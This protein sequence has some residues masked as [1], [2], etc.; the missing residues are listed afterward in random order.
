MDNRSI[1]AIVLIIL[2]W[3]GYS[4]FF[5][6]THIV[7]TV[8]PEITESANN[9]IKNQD[10]ININSF[11]GQIDKQD[12]SENKITE[13][14]VKS[15]LYTIIIS[16]EGASVKNITF[17]KY[18]ETN[19][20]NSELYHLLNTGEFSNY[21][22]K[23][24]LTDGFNSPANLIYKLNNYNDIIYKLSN[25]ELELV[26]ET[27]VDNIRITKI[28]SF[29]P[30]SYHIDIKHTFTNISTNA[31]TAKFNFHLVTPW[32]D[33]E[34]GDFY[35]FTGPLTYDGSSL[36]EDKPKSVLK[37]PVIYR[38]FIWSGFTTKYFLQALNHQ[39]FAEQ[40]LIS[41]QASSI[42]NKF[43]TS[44]FY[45]SPQQHIDYTYT[46]YIGPK[47]LE[48]LSISQMNFEKA[49]HFGFFHFLA[50]PLFD[51]LRFFY[52]F[53]NNYGF[54]IILLTVCIKL[55]FWP[56]THKSYK[57]MQGMQK[58]QPE[59]KRLREKYAGDKQKLN[60]ELMSFYKE[61]KINPLG[62]CLPILIQIPV[63]FALYKVLLDSIELRHAPFIFWISDLSSKDPYY[64]TPVI[65]GLSMFL[66][67]KLTPTNMDPMQEK[68]ML[69]MPI[70]FTFMFLN[71]PSGL[72]IYWLINN[73]LTIT[74]QL[75]IRR[76]SA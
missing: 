65:M 14:T 11:K 3:S 50:K 21:T 46:A 55:I 6:P 12:S 13:Y 20:K 17:N 68:I 28:Y 70:I 30:E 71:F 22:F 40:V 45:L 57:S 18:N 5:S 51:V 23:S 16:T 43:T 41:Y 25:E 29:Y 1:I 10:K 62:G 44:N 34:K 42:E 38:S 32:A 36:N 24:T 76:Q 75:I 19:N 31:L 47:N 33:D 48:Y 74:Q 67:Q 60:Q 73:L 27:V 52:S 72:V 69:M 26:F 64:I 63:F 59:M 9:I 58:L 37:N 8:A 56:L 7:P 53:L 39:G 61:N 49:I 35:T 2:L 4:I 66:Q 54:S 15:D